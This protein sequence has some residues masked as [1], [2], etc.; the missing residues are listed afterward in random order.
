MPVCGFDIYNA[1]SLNNTWTFFIY[2]SVLKLILD[3]YFLLTE[4]TETSQGPKE[5]H[6]HQG[7][8]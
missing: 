7:G 3:V 4:A 1:L 8:R 5:V 6:F 2:F